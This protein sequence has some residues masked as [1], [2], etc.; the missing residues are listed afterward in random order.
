[1]STALLDFCLDVIRADHKCFEV[2]T[3]PA[4]GVFSSLWAMWDLNGDK[5]IS[6]HE[7]TTALK[8]MDLDGNSFNSMLEVSAYLMRN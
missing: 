7:L 2:G 8:S 1:M 3:A 6:E 5:V 4:P